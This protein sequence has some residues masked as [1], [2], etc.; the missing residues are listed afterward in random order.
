[1]SIPAGFG[2][3][4]RCNAKENPSTMGLTA[5]VVGLQATPQV[6]QTASKWCQTLLATS[7]PCQLYLSWGTLQQFGERCLLQQGCPRSTPGTMSVPPPQ[8]AEVLVPPQPLQP[9][10]IPH[11]G[12]PRHQHWPHA[13]PGPPLP[14]SP[15]RAHPQL[16][17]SAPC[18]LPSWV[19]GAAPTP[20]PLTTPSPGWLLPPQWFI[21]VGARSP[22]QW[23]KHRGGATEGPQESEPRLLWQGPISSLTKAAM[24]YW[25]ATGNPKLQYLR[26]ARALLTALHG[27][28]TP[29]P[30]P[31]TGKGPLAHPLAGRG[32]RS[33][34]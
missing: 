19:W 18:P 25:R 15:G 14:Q 26:A 16:L 28:Q 33:N 3:F 4:K 5:V 2:S 20:S 10:S 11:Q 22:Q 24:Q 1:M 29:L 31:N 6:V 21:G 32:P 27:L 8:P 34:S 23:G 17:A 9:P 7:S 13:A 12:A 30:T